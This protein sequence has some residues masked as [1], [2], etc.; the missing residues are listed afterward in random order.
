[1]ASESKED[2]LRHVSPPL[3][4]P[5]MVM[6]PGVGTLD[7][8]ATIPDDAVFP[9]PNFTNYRLDAQKRRL[10]Q[11]ISHRGYKAIYPENTMASF[12][13]A[14]KVGTHALETDVHLTKDDVV[15]ISHDPS[16][17]RCYG[18]DKKIIDCNWDDIK[19]L[20]TVKEPHEPLPRLTDLLEYLAQPGL[21]EMWLLLD[22]K[23]SNDA[24]NIMRRLAATID[25]VAPP[26]SK[27]WKERVVL[28]IWAAKFLPFC[29]DYL[30]GFPV[31]HIGFSISYARHF[32]DVPNVSFN[33]LLPSLIA[34]G[35]KSF[36][37]DAKEKHNRQVYA[38]TVN[39]QDKM[40]WCIRK[41]LDGV[42]TD[43]PKK[44]LEVCERFDEKSKAPWLPVSFRGY[45]EVLRVWLWVRIAILLFFGKRLEPKASRKLIRRGA[46]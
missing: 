42:I 11:C 4:P 27:A 34:P 31:S 20:K 5:P 28:G 19:D 17:K 44:F 23:L 45:L 13:G 41:Q 14:V 7:N 2:L 22:I 38:W 10:P 43:D 30:P 26:S 46:K 32:F 29:V 6:Q 24:E 16:L 35:G 9:R 40:E 25:S 39:E 1:M 12:K 21:E 36:L 18:L 8:A 37:R 3:K 33:M 15:I